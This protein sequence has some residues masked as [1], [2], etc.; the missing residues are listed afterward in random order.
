MKMKANIGLSVS[1]IVALDVKQMLFTI[2][3]LFSR[4]IFIL[5]QLKLYGLRVLI[6]LELAA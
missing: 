1:L 2:I 6:E 4:K 5:I 3:F